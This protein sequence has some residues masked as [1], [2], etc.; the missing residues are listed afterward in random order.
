MVDA[1]VGIDPVAFLVT[2]ILL[3]LLPGPDMAIVARNTIV[4]GRAAGLRCAYGSLLGLTI[5]EVLAVAGL[6]AIIATSATAFTVVKI[7]GAVYLV[8]LGLRVIAGTLRSGDRPAE[9]TPFERAALPIALTPS[10][11][12]LQGTLS[13]SL[14]PKIAVFMMTFL[15][16]FVDPDDHP[17]LSLLAHGAVLALFT[18]VWLW[19]W[20]R[21][22][23]R[24]AGHLR[25][26]GVR[27]WAE[28]AIGAV[29]LGLG[30]RL[31]FEHR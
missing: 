4:H 10:S 12:L 22:L 9:T 19:T 17:Q 3:V 25:R 30:I 24:L 13:S 5:Q 20:V 21:M 28:R 11:P 8:L 27:A 7:A 26:P 15:P 6:S 31:A 18:I 1:L 14:N 23:D 16:Q 2:S 29:V